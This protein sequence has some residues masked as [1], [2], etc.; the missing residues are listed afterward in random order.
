MLKL[1]TKHNVYE[2]WSE[3]AAESVFVDCKPTPTEVNTLWKKKW[4]KSLHRP[5]IFKLNP[6]YTQDPA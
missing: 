3:D 6:V 5:Q 2:V 4:P 1:T